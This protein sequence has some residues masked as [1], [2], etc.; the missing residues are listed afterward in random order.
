MKKNIKLIKHIKFYN[1]ENGNDFI[2]P[3]IILS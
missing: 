2:N 1:Y 3:I